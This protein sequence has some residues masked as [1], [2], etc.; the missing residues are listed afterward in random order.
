M[1]YKLPSKRRLKF[2]IK[3]EAKA[4]KEYKSYGYKSLAKDEGSH[5][6]F[7]KKILKERD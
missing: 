6:K 7:L 5:R 3:D 2:L 4:K 1:A